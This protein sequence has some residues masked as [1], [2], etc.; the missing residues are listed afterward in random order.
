MPHVLVAGII[1][2]AAETLLSGRSDVTYEIVPA[3]TVEQ[4]QERIAD[5]DGIILRVTRFGADGS[6]VI[7]AA[8]IDAMKPGAILINVARGSL[9]DETALAKALGSGRPTGAGIDVFGVEPPADDNPLLG[10]DNTDFS[11]LNA[12]LTAECI[13]RMSEVS[14]QNVLD[15]L[16]DRL[17]P[18]LVINREV[19]G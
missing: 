5:I 16:D 17:D 7:G 13:R 6:P 3:A 11:P 15:A 12:A 2:E 1:D 9:V 19:L 18:E 4:I 10:L 8:E 14:A